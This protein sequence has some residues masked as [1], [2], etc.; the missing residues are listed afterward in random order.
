MTRGGIP[1]DLLNPGQVFACLG[2]VEISEQIYG[3]TLSGFE[4]SDDGVCRFRVDSSGSEDP[5]GD[6][7]E[8][9]E[10]SEVRLVVPGDGSRDYD[11]GKWKLDAHPL[12]EGERVFPMPPPEKPASLPAALVSDDRIVM[13]AS[14]G[15]ATRRDKV[16]FWA[17]A[18]GYPGA[19][20][21]RD[22][23]DLVRG[24]MR[25]ARAD[26]FGLAVPQKG[27]LR[28]DWR[29]DYVPLGV[30]FSPNAHGDVAPRGYPLVE[31]L[32]AVGL[33]HARPSRPDRRD[34]LLYRYAVA[35]GQM[36]PVQV[37]RAVLGDVS[38]PFPIRRFRIRLGWPGQENQ[39]RCITS[40]TEEPVA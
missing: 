4:W 27:S 25:S 11:H 19:A 24:R 15:D 38:M 7:L 36:L 29:R 34:K 3:P 22:A 16:K 9:L 1:V 28:F 40:V 33:A 2:I 31:V 6:A 26:P 39:A 13:L 20:F 30:G 8:F 10:Q 23:L 32:A 37:H 18:G 35:G 21:V 12:A 5:I 14:W 17:G